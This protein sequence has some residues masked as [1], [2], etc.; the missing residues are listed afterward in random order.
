[1][2]WRDADGVFRRAMR[3]LGVPFLRRWIMWSAVRWASLKNRAAWSESGLLLDLPRMLFFSLV[4]A[5]I[6][7]PPAVLILV[8]LV[9]WL[10]VESLFWVPL[11]LVEL[12]KRRF[13]PELRRK[14]VNAP[15][16]EWKV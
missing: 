10:V 9:A 3:D 14:Q 8:A 12:T 5:P 2:R 15:T 1:M 11:K 16:L 7:V 4:A 13:F 6:V